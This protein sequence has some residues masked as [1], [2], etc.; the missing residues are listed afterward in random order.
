MKPLPS[1]AGSPVRL[2][3]LDFDGTIMVYDE[4]P[5]FFHPDIIALL[6]QLDRRGVRWVAN[7]GRDARDQQLVLEKSR[8]KGLRHPP[9]AL[10]CSESLIFHRRPG[11]YAPHEPW[12]T[13]V[14]GELGP[15]QE[16]IQELLEPELPRLAEAYG[17]CPV[18]FGPNYTAFNLPDG[19]GLPLRFCAARRRLLAGLPGC[20]IPRNGGGVAVRGDGGGRGNTLRKSA[21]TA[22]YARHEILAVGDQFNDLNM[23]DGQSAL[24]VGCPADALP[25]VVATVRV[26]GGRVAQ[27]DGPAGTAEILRHFLWS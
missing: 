23:L 11:G 3:C 6:N 20:M 15:L 9:E 26:A 16:R 19:A 18:Y 12:N 24:H 4:P 8:R 2:V 10:L 14:Y 22:G 13:R 27:A 17:Y 5:G 21:P 1:P 7:S 25:E